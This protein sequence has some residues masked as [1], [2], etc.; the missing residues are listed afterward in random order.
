MCSCYSVASSSRSVPSLTREFRRG[1]QRERDRERAAARN[2]K[3]KGSQDG[4][5]P[6]QRRERCVFL[7]FPG[8][9]SDSIGFGQA[10]SLLAC[11]D[12]RSGVFRVVQGQEG[13][14]GEGGQKGTAGSVGLRRWGHLYR[15]QE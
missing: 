10:A 4:L 1:N 5:T 8:F 11:A 14:G 13:A 7:I 6:E 15:L 3:S 12:V 2:P 9:L